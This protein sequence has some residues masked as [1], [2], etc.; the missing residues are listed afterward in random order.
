MI[1]IFDENFMDFQVNSFK[2][3]KEYLNIHYSL[4]MMR[5]NNYRFFASLNPNDIDI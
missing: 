4:K 1:C 3:I 5:D 2:Y